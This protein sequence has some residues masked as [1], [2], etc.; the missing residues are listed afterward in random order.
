MAKPRLSKKKKEIIAT[1]GKLKA[2]FSDLGQIMAEVEAMQDI[3]RKDILECGKLISGDDKTDCGNRTFVRAVFA[4]IEGGTYGFKQV[5][6][7][8][9][10]HGRGNFH[11]SRNLPL[12]REVI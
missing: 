6:L 10:K 3:L 12:R 7:K 5:A 9:A 11:S 2:E 1:A 4:L 8:L